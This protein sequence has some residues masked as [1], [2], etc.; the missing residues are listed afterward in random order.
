VQEISFASKLKDIAFQ[1]YGWAGIKRA[2]YYETHRDDKEKV[3]PLI[4]K[5]PRQIWI[6][7]GNKC[8]EIYQATWIDYALNGVNGDVIIITDMGFT[9]EAT[10][11]LAKGGLLVKLVRDGI[12]LGTDPREIELDNWD[13]WDRIIKN[14]GSLDD[15]YQE[16]VKLWTEIK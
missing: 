3:L 2:V 8:R 11:I 5:S 6:E 16:A 7:L 13:N 9:N 10:A 14:N 12:L 4:G 1:L 15:L